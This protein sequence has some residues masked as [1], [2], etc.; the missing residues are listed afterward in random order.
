MAYEANQKAELRERQED[1]AHVTYRHAEMANLT[2]T[3]FSLQSLADD[4]ALFVGQPGHVLGPIGE[5]P[6]QA[7]AD[8]HD[9]QSFDDE[10]PLPSRDARRRRSCRATSPIPVRR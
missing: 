4:A 3:P 5:E 8:Q 1:H 10:Q 7:D 9:R 2:R 6:E